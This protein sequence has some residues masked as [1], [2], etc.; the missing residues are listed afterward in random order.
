MCTVLQNLKICHI[1]C[2]FHST[3]LFEPTYSIFVHKMYASEQFAYAIEDTHSVACAFGLEEWQPD[4]HNENMEIIHERDRMYLA[5]QYGGS[6]A[7]SIDARQYETRAGA[8][9]VA[10]WLSY[11][12]L[13]PQMYP[14]NRV[15]L[16]DPPTYLGQLEI[17][18]AGT[19]DN[20]N[21]EYHQREWTSDGNLPYEGGSRTGDYRHTGDSMRPYYIIEETRKWTGDSGVESAPLN[22]S[23]KTASQ[24]TSPKGGFSSPIME[25]KEPHKAVRNRYPIVR[26]NGKL[27]LKALEGLTALELGKHIDLNFASLSFE[28]VISTPWNEQEESEGRR[29]VRITK[30]Q[31]KNSILVDLLILNSRQTLSDSEAESITTHVD[32]SC[33]KYFNE[34]EDTAEFLITSLDVIKIVEFLIGNSGKNLT[35]KRKERGRI[36][37]NL[38]PLWH[39]GYTDLESDQIKMPLRTFFERIKSYEIQK[40]INISKSVRLLLWGNLTLAL[41]RALDFYRVIVSESE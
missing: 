28:G 24:Q 30:R 8:P 17:T 31:K 6:F 1:N 4:F 13:R 12:D 33:L 9:H 5:G 3:L 18:A 15:L 40:P 37:S 39:K 38:V 2:D 22:G 27:N 11:D 14:A 19:S 41:Y 20:N 10:C 26:H 29:I 32:V 36:R 21:Q 23:A 7:S 34:E 35:V 16:R 25:M